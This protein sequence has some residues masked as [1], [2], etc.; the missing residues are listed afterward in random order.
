[1]RWVSLTA[2]AIPL[3]ASGGCADYLNHRDSITLAA[4]DAPNFNQAVHTINPQSPR[5]YNTNLDF[6][7][8]RA[9][10]VIQG[11]SVPPPPPPPPTV[12]INIGGGANI[13]GG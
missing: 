1:M 10:Y 11:Y 7:G 13:N 3:F 4:G 5:A 6:S 12:N 8:K 2:L 9:A